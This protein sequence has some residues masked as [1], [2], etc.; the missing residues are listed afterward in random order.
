MSF[1]FAGRF[2]PARRADGGYTF[3]LYAPAVRSVDVNVDGRTLPL[4]RDGDW[5]SVGDPLARPGSRYQFVIDGELTIPDPA[6]RFAPEGVHGPSE[7]VDPNSFAWPAERPKPRPWN[8]YV[9]YELHVGT[10]TDAGTYSA[11]IAHLDALAEIGITAIELMPIAAFPGA[12]NWGY[13]GVMPYAPFAGY[14]TPDELKQFIAEAHGRGLAVL[15]DVVYNHFGPDGNYLHTIAPTFFTEKFHT[16]W[17][18]A[19]DFSHPDVRAFFIENA[20]YWLEEFCFDGLR[21]DATHAIIDP[22]EP[23][24]LVELL[25]D[26]TAY[27]TGMAPPLVLENESNDA[28]LLDNGY[29]AQWNDD[30]HNAAHVIAT[31]ETE[32]YYEDYE[33]DPVGLFVRALTGGFA[34]RGEPSKHHDGAPRGQESAALCATAFVNFLQNHDQ[35]GNRAFG[36]RIDQLASADAVHGMHA[37]LWLAPAIPLM[38]MGEEWAA[39]TPFLFFADFSGDLAH[40]VTEGRRKEFARFSAF[41]DPDA[42]DRIPDP[43]A[44]STF[45]ASRL[46][47]D[48]RASEPHATALAR[49][50]AILAARRQFITPRNESLTGANASSERIGERGMRVTYHGGDWELHVDAQL[51]GEPGSGFATTLPGTMIYATHGDRYD[52]GIAPAWAVR[53]SLA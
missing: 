27:A 48:E 14:G 32:A 13:D 25:R 49:T 42:R 35:I 41:A 40:A 12:R 28:G 10:F 21:L 37:L 5:F 43:I 38:F 44:E 36:E 26:V 7:I 8:E 2:G 16:P 31:G 51:A 33:H 19:I 17:G 23:T 46:N 24:V 11:V 45:A 30:I 3:R 47:W 1:A 39:S 18:A 9:I 29:A 15:L 4:V 53:W 20:R 6:A 50:R 34:Y 22:S 52:D